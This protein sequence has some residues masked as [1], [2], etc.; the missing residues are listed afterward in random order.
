MNITLFLAFLAGGLLYFTS[1]GCS[2]ITELGLDSTEFFLRIDLPR[3][4]PFASP[5]AS[6]LSLDFPRPNCSEIS[7]LIT[8]CCPLP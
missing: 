7:L 5:L 3:C 6:L 8:S 4:L 1:S 2:W